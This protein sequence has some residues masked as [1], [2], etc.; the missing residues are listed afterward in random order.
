VL[1]DL[2]ADLDRLAPHG[3][4]VLAGYSM[5]GRVALQLA[6]AR[7][8]RVAALVLV[9][10]TAGI[11]DPAQRA[12]RRALDDARARELEDEGVASFAAR[13]VALPLWDGDP[14]AVREQQRRELE[15]G[16]VA[17]L[18]AALRGLSPGAVPAVWDRLPALRPPL[19]VVVGGRDRRYRAL[20][21][22]LVAE[23]PE[24]PREVVI[25]GAGHGLLREAPAAVAAALRAL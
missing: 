19:T 9:S 8:D 10:S 5:G 3:P 21:R 17:G 15:A 22:R 7:P 23:A 24:S 4:A 25:A 14:V 2:D 6:L 12:Q 16:D 20:G 18:A 1:T 13:W 11:E